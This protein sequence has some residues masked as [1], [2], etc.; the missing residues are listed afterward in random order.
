[1]RFWL[2][3]YGEDADGAPAEGIGTLVA[4]DADAATAGGPLAFAG[5]AVRAP[6]PSWVAAHPSLDV[7]YAALE[8]AGTVQAFERVAVDRMRPLG[9]PV[10]AGASA[11]HVAVAPDGAFVLVSCWG[12]G[13][14]VR[15][16]LGADGTLGTARIA[17]P[18]TDPYGPAAPAASPSDPALAAAARALRAAAGAEYADLVPDYDDEPA[19]PVQDAAPE[20][21]A[22]VSRAHEA[23]FLP[24]GTVLTT[25]LGYDLVRVWHAAGPGLRRGQQLALPQGCGPRHMVW[26]P[27]GHVYV[28]TEYTR[29]VFVLT[30]DAEGAWH[31][32]GGVPAG[33]GGLDGD[34]GAEIALSRDAHVVYAGIRGSDTIAVLRVRGAGEALE[35]VALVEAG[36]RTPRHHA[37]VHD[38]LIVAGQTSDEVVSHALDPRTGVPGG[39]RHRA[40]APAP[41]C[42]LPVRGR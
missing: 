7:V 6:S 36:V 40:A 26:H 21:P 20:E 24:D 14:V 19:Q 22:R 34:T 3:G 30:R 1:M 25:D 11:C 23:L 15:V 38:T 29:E 8:G 16:P 2:G 12:D 31:V 17:P 27:S 42:V 33:M 37:V 13:R 18:A 28:L 10:E 32:R 5:T 41:T 39:V 4:G 35:P 9:A